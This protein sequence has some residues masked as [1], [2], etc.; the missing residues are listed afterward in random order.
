MKKSRLAVACFFFIGGICFASWASRIPNIKQLLNLSDA[1]LGGVL[2]ALPV[3]SMCSLPVSGWLVSSWGSKKSLLT[4]A[5]LYPIVLFLIGQS[6]TVFELVGLLFSYGFI[7]NLMNI[8]V[9]TQAVGIESL[10]KRSVMASFHGVWSAA[11]FIGATIGT[12]MINFGIDPH[13]HFI[14]VGMVML[15]IVG[16]TQQHLLLIDTKTANQ[17]IY[18]KPDSFLWKLGLI[19]FSCMVCEGTMFDWSGVYFQ[20]IVNAPQE[21]TTL[22]YVAFMSTMAGGRFLGDRLVMQ[23]GIKKMLGLSGIFI[24]AGLL[25]AVFFPTMLLATLGFLLV[26]MGVSSVVPIVY[27]QAGKSTKMAPG[28][29]IAAVSSIGFLGFLIGPPIIGFIAQSFGLQWSFSLIALLG[30]GTSLLARIS[31]FN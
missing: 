24:A 18:S 11:G 3:G 21:Y 17:P 1:A 31:T 25:M 10:Y 7:G 20:K 2:F 5:I 12:I 28:V 15:L 4:G 29:A 13:H 30:L 16:V 8:S 6:N 19:S 22:G 26:G 23:W 9:N 27:S 14:L